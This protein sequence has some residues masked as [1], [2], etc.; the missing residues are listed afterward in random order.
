[1][2]LVTDI[3][4]IKIQHPREV[5]ALTTGCTT[6]FVGSTPMFINSHPDLQMRESLRNNYLGYTI[7]RPED[8]LLVFGLAYEDKYANNQHD[9]DYFV[10]D[11]KKKTI[12][13]YYGKDFEKLYTM[14]TGTHHKYQSHLINQQ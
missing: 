7:S 11:I 9:E 2:S 8:N 14:Y 3:S 12:T 5:C 10:H 13:R 1:M 4:G 6:Y